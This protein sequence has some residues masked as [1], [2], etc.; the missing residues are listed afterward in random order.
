L[1]YAIPARI[2]T[3]L[4]QGHH[5][6]ANVSRL[7]IA[8]ARARY[9]PLRVICVTA[10]PATVAERLATRGRE[11]AEEIASRLARGALALPEG[12]DVAVVT[13]DGTLEEGIERMLEILRAPVP[14]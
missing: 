8:D 1:S 6:V 13:N 10:S 11:N 14:L 4:A 7:I 2:D 9:R 3:A 5:V 12:P